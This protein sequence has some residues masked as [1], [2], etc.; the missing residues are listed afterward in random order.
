MLD[1]SVTLIIT[2]INIAVLFFIL[3]AILFKPVTKFMADRTKKIQDLIDQAENNKTQART[4]LAQYEA[5]LKKAESEAEAI[6]RT[7]RENARLE[8]DKIIAESR[9]AS[10]ATLANTR[11]QLVEE[12]N[13]AL[14]VFR[15][16]AAAIV[17]TATSRLVGRELQN[18]DNMQYAEMLLE[19]ISLP[20]GEGK[21]QYV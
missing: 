16:E 4:L 9:A 20:S 1:F 11:R 2:I 10:E 19:E 7:A 5:Q 17:V 14:A 13:A 3:R 8:A 18:D 15:K 21:D 12:R 6:I